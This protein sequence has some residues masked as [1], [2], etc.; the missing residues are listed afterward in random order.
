[1]RGLSPAT[2]SEFYPE[3]DAHTLANAHA[4]HAN[5]KRHKAARDAAGKLAKTTKDKAV[6]MDMVAQGKPPGA[7]AMAKVY[8]KYW[9]P[10]GRIT[11]ATKR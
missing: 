11:R 10:K 4:I 9:G 8:E 6:G 7:E 1:M 3:S 2:P 5:P